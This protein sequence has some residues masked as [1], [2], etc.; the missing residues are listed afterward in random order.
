M[1]I[2]TLIVFLP[3]L[4]G[5]VCLVVPKRQVRTVAVTFALA[6]F[7]L[8]LSLFGTFL[9]SS[10]G[11]TETI[12]GTRYGTLQHVERA[13]WITGKSFAIEYFLG[14]DGLGF[15]L[16]IL[17]TLVS[18]LAC[19]AS[20]GFDHWHI[21]RGVRAYFILFLLLETGRIRIR[22]LCP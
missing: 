15:P 4:G 3:A 7:V 14:I 10:E 20:W 19:V 22:I 9:A 6:T 5:L 8:S 16:F 2:L 21:N 13:T 17:T 18:F 1:N 12:F 11:S